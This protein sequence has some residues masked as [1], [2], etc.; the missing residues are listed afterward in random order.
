M[1]YLDELLP[2]VEL[3]E[4]DVLLVRPAGDG[5]EE[6]AAA[7]DVRVLGQRVLQ[8]LLQQAVQ[9]E[10]GAEGAQGLGPGLH[11]HGQD[12]GGGLA[13]WD[14]RKDNSVN[15]NKDNGVR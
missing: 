10:P 1:P 8:P 3:W 2:G 5:D 9:V 4:Q 15:V 6:A 14:E 7:S 12:V 11:G 13:W